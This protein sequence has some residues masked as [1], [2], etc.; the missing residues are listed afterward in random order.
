MAFKYSYF[1]LGNFVNGFGFWGNCAGRAWYNGQWITPY[2]ATCTPIPLDKCVN[3]DRWIVGTTQ[4]GTT[5]RSMYRA[6]LV[7]MT[8]NNNVAGTS[9]DETLNINVFSSETSNWLAA[10]VIIYSRQ[11]TVSEIQQIEQYLW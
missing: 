9:T 4:V 7:D 3:E 2:M 1:N 5:P 10:E 6:Q 11:L 8:I